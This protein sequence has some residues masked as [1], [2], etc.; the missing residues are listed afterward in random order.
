MDSRNSGHNTVN[1]DD[2]QGLAE[3]LI[4]GACQRTVW[5]QGELDTPRQDW[6]PEEVPSITVF[7]T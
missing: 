3:R 6:L 2:S 5:H 4:A 7:H 1:N